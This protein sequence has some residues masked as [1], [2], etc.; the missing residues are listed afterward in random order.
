MQYRLLIGASALAVGLAGTWVIAQSRPA[1]ASEEQ[2]IR[3]AAEA[4]AEAFNKGDLSGVLAVWAESA[5]YVDEAGKTI[6]G[7]QALTA[8]YKKAFKE[9]KGLKVRIVT[10]TIRFLKTDVA[11]QD[12][13]ALLTHAGGET[14]VSPFT[15]I[16]IKK[17]GQW[18]VAH[19]REL[20][21]EVG[22]V[23]EEA[24]T[25]LNELGWL[26]GDWT[27]DDKDKKTTLAGHWMKGHKFL[28]LDYSVNAKGDEILALTQ[29]IGWDPTS[30]KLHSWVFDS[31]GGFGEGSWSRRD[32]TWTV[33]VA[34]V[35][36]DGRQ[37]T[38]T[39]QWTHVDDNTFIFQSLDR[40]IDGQP[41]PEVKI[42]YTRTGKS[43]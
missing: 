28:V 23:G 8:M 3:K 43:K 1:Q 15:A 13:S 30:E 41:F 9:N 40:E 17:D 36:A 32:R 12:G 29:I 38:G 11:S 18:L 34:G 24:N 2:T 20:P 10:T 25:R 35:V 22:R 27:H 21:S 31:R 5:D 6:E 16:W 7:R 37:G 4:Y 39:N 42:T 26:V 33:A 14:E 19:L